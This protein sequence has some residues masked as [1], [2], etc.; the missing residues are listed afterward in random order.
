MSLAEQSQQWYPTSV[1][2]T[3]LQARKL[4][5]K[6]KNGTNDAYAIIQVAKDKFSTAVAEKCVDPV[7]KEEASFDLP[8]FHR[9]NAERCTLYI[10][11]MHR[12]LVGMDKLL[13]QAVINL[14]D[15]HDNKARK[16]TDWY[17]LLDKNGKADKERGEVLLD[18]QFMRNNMTASMFDLSMQDKP[19]SR[20]SKLKDKVRGKKKDGL[21]DSASAIVPAT[22]SQVLTDSEG[23]EE[24]STDSPKLKKSSKFK[25]LFGSKTNLHRGVSQSMSTLGT[26]PEK[27][28]SLSSSRSSGLNEES[29]EGKNKFKFLGHK[30]NSSTDSKISLGPFT[31][32]NRSKQST[33]EQ[34]NLCINGSHV[35]AEDQETKP[36]SGSSLSLSGSAKGSIEDLRKYHER[37]PSAGSTDSFKGLSI[38]S[39]KPDSTDR[40]FQVQQRPQE[41]EEKKHKKTEGRLQELLDEQE[42]KRQQEQDERWRK[43]EEDERKMQQ[44]RERKRQEEEEQQRRKR[45]EEARKA[46][47]QKRQE[48]SRVTERLTSLFGLG[49][50]KEEQISPA[51]ESPKQL[52]V[53]ASTNPFEE[54]PLGSDSPN[55]FLEEKPAEPQKEVRTAFTPM[56]PSSGF[57]ARTAK[58]SAVKPRLTL[59]QKTETDNTDSLASPVPSDIQNSVPA[60]TFS[61]EAS[62]SSDS[63]E[64]FDMFSNLHSS[65]APPKPQRT[66]SD[67]SRGSM[68]NRSGVDNATN[69]SEKK[70]RAAQSPSY[71]G[72]PFKNEKHHLKNGVQVSPPTSE[73]TQKPSLPPPD[74][75]ALFPK[76][77]HGVMTDTRWEH[78]IA[79]VNQRKMNFQDG[80][81]EMSVDGPDEPI[82]NKSSILKE[83]NTSSLNQHHRDYQAVSSAPTK[84][85]EPKPALIPPKPASL[86]TTKQQRE[87]NSEQ[88]H[89]HKQ[90]YSVH[91]EKT[92]TD[93]GRNLGPSG[94]SQQDTRMNVKG[95]SNPIPDP[96]LGQISEPKMEKP[97]PTAR[98][99]K[100]PTS[101]SDVDTTGLP[102]AKHRKGAPSKEPVI[103]VQPEQ[104]MLAFTSSAS[105]Q[106]DGKKEGSKTAK[107]L[108]ENLGFAEGKP[109]PVNKTA[110]TVNIPKE[111]PFTNVTSAPEKKMT[112]VDP[113]PSDKLISQDPWALPQQT[114]DQDDFFTGGPKEGKKPEDQR[115]SSD[116]FDNIFGSG[117]S[118]NEMDPFFVPKDKANIFFESVASKNETDLKKSHNSSP[119]SQ[120]VYSQK[121]KLAPPP[122]E[123]PV[124]GKD[125]MDKPVLQEADDVE[126]TVTS[127]AEPKGGE[128]TEATSKANLDPFTSLSSAIPELLSG[129]A[130]GGKSTLCAWVS[131]SE[132]QSGP[133][134]SS[135][136][137]VVFTSRRPHPVK[138]MSPYESQSPG[139]ISSGKDLKI[140]TIREV[141][142]KSKSV[143]CGP[144]TQ[145]TQE[146]LITLVVKQQTE[147][148]KKDEKILELEDYID[149]LLVRVIDEKPSILLAL[150]AKV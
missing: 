107:S 56:P 70:Y 10:V 140:P 41:D 38:P 52:E 17:K 85:M 98:S 28:S 33:P 130:S 39:Y 27:N 139:S 114:M 132:V 14:L 113:F 42:R 102:L 105:S 129:S 6:G 37:K 135:G 40:E 138:P 29:A 36:N 131:P 126:L 78:I 57:P 68:E 9:G 4:R 34:S 77:R 30:R 65:M 35:Y 62:P 66:F 75:E 143:E 141:A 81:K 67:S 142:E 48:E 80:E 150:N 44:E 83:R 149:N 116:D 125:T 136:G 31:L 96:T 95:A 72:D 84:G 86:A 11:V 73:K 55:P 43:L 21:S 63:F 148:S 5:L 20:I 128:T 123:K 106:V 69:L 24:G 54:I 74:Y 64:S 76:K 45:E 89:T 59:S 32:L 120:K 134:Q 121:K 71:P 117:A 147:L 119:S 51:V 108:W 111:Q 127:L 100:K 97:T 53:P 101:S 137:G 92:K 112:E 109:T 82:S 16:N 91:G 49:R 99:I 124:M 90:L 115:L 3:V 87:A 50:K 93:L 58:V 79:E 104:S 7:W 1:Q 19:R 61:P 122:P 47:E 25:S 8:L 145:L 94:Q 103:Q 13:G 15:V 26:L 23:E 12:A 110:K 146:E 88:G 60:S 46:E 2:V 18:I 133:S 22:V 118:K 144:Y